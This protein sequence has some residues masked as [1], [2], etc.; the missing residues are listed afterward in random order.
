MD[1][2]LEVLSDAAKYDSSCSSSG[3]DRPAQRDGIGND[4]LG[5]ICHSFS[6]NRQYISLP[7][8]LLTNYCIAPKHDILPLIALHFH[9]RF[10]DERVIFDENRQVAAPINK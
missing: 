3:S 8:V 7:K 1:E 10:K 4:A 5:G 2:K 9:D 6:A